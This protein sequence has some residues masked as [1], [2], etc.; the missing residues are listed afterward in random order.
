MM[1]YPHAPSRLTE[2]AKL[3]YDEATLQGSMINRVVLYVIPV[4]NERR[5]NPCQELL[6]P[7]R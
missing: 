3:R 4:S 6:K 1:C 7:A 2:W 5:R